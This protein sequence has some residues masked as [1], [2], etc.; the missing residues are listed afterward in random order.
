MSKTIFQKRC[1]FFRG[2][3]L[4]EGFVYVVKGRGV[5]GKPTFAY[6]GERGSKNPKTLPTQFVDGPFGC[7]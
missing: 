6:K 4:S 7:R 2:G 5:D 1:P 3:G